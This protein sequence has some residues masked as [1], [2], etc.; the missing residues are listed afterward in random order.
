MSLLGFSAA[1]ASAYVQLGI[2]VSRGLQVLLR[3]A[4]MRDER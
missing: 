2:T 1:I 4:G 3:S